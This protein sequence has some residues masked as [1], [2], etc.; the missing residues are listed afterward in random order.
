MTKFEKENCLKCKYIIREKLGTKEASCS[1]PLEKGLPPCLRKVEA[2][3]A[4][5]K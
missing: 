4:L 1:F 5:T 3:V 2:I